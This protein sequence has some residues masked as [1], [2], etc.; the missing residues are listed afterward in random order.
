MDVFFVYPTL[1]TDK[2][3]D[4]WNASINDSLFN[5]EILNE[6]LALNR[7]TL[8]LLQFELEWLNLRKKIK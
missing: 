1:L 7:H 3:N 6:E 4:A 2:K 5:Q 8:K